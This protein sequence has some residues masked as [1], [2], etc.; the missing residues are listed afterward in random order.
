MKDSRGS[1][2]SRASLLAEVTSLIGSGLE[3]GQLFSRLTHLVVPALGD[4]CAIDVVY[5]PDVI[6][7]VAYAHVD[8]AKE[9]LVGEVRAAHGFNAESPHGVPAALRTRRSIVIPRVTGA[10]LEAEARNGEQ[11]AV[12]R[13]IGPK[14]WMVVPMVGRRQVLGAMTLAVTESPRRYGRADLGLAELVAGQLVVALENARA[15]RATEKARAAAEMANRA[16]DEFLSRLSHE[17]RN[18]LN[19]VVGWARMLED[20]RLSEEQTRRA[21]QVILR[22]TAAQT[23]L[24]DDLLDLE[25]VESGKVPLASHP[26]DLPQ[27]VTAAL[28]DIRPVAAAKDVSLRD[29]VATLD[30]RVSGDAGRL[31]QV[32]GNL[33]SN[34][35]KFTPRGGS[36]EVSLRQEGSHA[37]IV[38]SDTGEGIPAHRLPH[39]FDRGGPAENAVRPSPHGLGVGLAL[40]RHLVE[41]HGGTVFAE[42]A[43][44]GRGSTFVVELPLGV[45]SAPARH[46]ALERTAPEPP[47]TLRDMRVLLVDDDPLIIQVVGEA[48][49]HAGADVRGCESVGAALD[50][51]AGWQPDVIVSDIEMPGDDGYAL[52]RAVRALPPEQGGR[53][54]ALALT[55]LNRTADRIRSLMAGFNMH[56]PKPVDPAE[57][58]AI[59]ASL[60]RLPR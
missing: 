21:V 56:V 43:G 33:L 23:R 22:N 41:Q 51:L 2:E 34:A 14:S 24:L 36:I 59:V 25:V 46:V 8:A 9:P 58:T 18:P 10:H 44:P 60:A 28:E 45:A 6:S 37:E 7:R 27:L 42:S 29:V 30:A 54:P 15:Q 17:L 12:L 49:A 3:Q 1:R 26:V 48:L 38:I 35:V 39:I 40:V 53:T 52:V 11:L 5:E 32:L 50:A 57:L 13:R 55:A 31:Q 19:A 20:G 47:P 16:K 4:L